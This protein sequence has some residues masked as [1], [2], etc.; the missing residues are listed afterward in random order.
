LEIICGEGQNIQRIEV[1]S[2]NEEE[3]L[4]LY[5]FIDVPCIRINTNI[6][7]W[8]AKEPFREEKARLL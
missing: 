3:K 5:P 1:V 2:P 4:D 8:V 7:Y 6:R